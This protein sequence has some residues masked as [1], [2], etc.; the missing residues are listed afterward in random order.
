IVVGVCSI[1]AYLWFSVLSKETFPEFCLDGSLAAF[2]LFLTLAS[3]LGWFCLVLALAALGALIKFSLDTRKLGWEWMV[4][5]LCGFCWIA[6]AAFYFYMPLAGMTN[7]P[8]EWGYPRTVEGFFHAFTRGQY[9]KTNPT[10]II[11]HPLTFITQLGMMWDGIVEE[12][13][14]LYA[15]LGLI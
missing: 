4:V 14:W 12:F 3:S 13:N 1:L 11:H 10:D 9:E 5:I 2:F 8:M 7:P 15:L 6:G